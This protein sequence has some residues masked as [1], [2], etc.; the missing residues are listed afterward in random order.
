[1]A[2]T[3]ACAQLAFDV[4]EHRARLRV[5]GANAQC[6]QQASPRAR[7]VAAHL[8]DLREVEVGRRSA[9]VEFDRALQVAL[10]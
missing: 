9:G 10:A 7:E 2:S 1:M 4:A 5:I 6:F 8:E 3:S